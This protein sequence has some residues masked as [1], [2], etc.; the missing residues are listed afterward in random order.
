MPGILKNHKRIILSLFALMLCFAMMTGCGKKSDDS[1]PLSEI[2]KGNAMTG[3]SCHD[4]ILF[5]MKIL[6]NISCIFVPALL[7]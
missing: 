2:N 6:I 5:I 3:I 1:K 7:T 4:P